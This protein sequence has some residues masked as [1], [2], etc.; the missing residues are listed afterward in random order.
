MSI[1][2]VPLIP[3]EELFGDPMKLSPRVSPDGT[4]FAYLAP[5]EGVLN[6][7]LRTMGKDD[8][9]PITRER[10]RGIPFF[11]FTYDNRHILYINDKDG[12]ENYRIHAVDLETNEIRDL[13]PVEGVQARIYGFDHRFPNEI[14]IGLNDRDARVHDVH[15]LNIATGELTLEVENQDGVSEWL[16]DSQFQVRGAWVPTPDG[17]NDLRVRDSAGDE[18]RVLKSW[19][20]FELSGAFGWTDD[21]SGI[22]LMD[23]QDTDKAELRVIDAATGE[24]KTL[25]GDPKV[26][27]ADIVMRRIDRKVQAA[28]F[29]SGRINWMVL[30]PDVERDFAYLQ[31]AKDGQFIIVSRDLA[32]NLWIVYYDLD[33]TPPSYYLYDRRK[34][35]LEFLFTSRPDLEKYPLAEMRSIE[36]KSRDGLTLHCYLS[37]PP[38]AEARNLPMVLNVHG[39]PWAQDVWG[40]AIEPQWLA[41]RGYACLQV[42]YRGSTGYGKSFIN[43]GN[44][45]W[46]GKMHDDLID[47]VNWAIFEGI[48]DPKRIAIYGGSYGGYAALVGAAF[49]PK[50]FCCAVDIVGISNMRTFLNSL[51]PYW[52]IMRN[53]LN[54]RVGRLDETD[55]LDSRSP[56]FKADQIECPLMIAQGANDPRVKQAESEQI[57]ASL[58]ERGKPVEYILFQDEGHGFARP[59]NRLTFYAAAEKF[60][61][62]HLGG[63]CL[64]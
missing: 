10:K 22:Y 56:L 49:T 27:L 4:R 52:E 11:F 63:R 44:R 60:L 19:G 14:L 48:A 7:W 64:E 51:P 23:S 47:A 59:E 8:D 18:W 31:T 13:T 61:A 42:N 3:R 36:I 6:V 15:R 12:D 33:D 37:L 46:G 40:F 43:A 55:F 53:M 38:G 16:V 2:D 57:V 29:R 1:S 39:G 62:E 50:V 24:V 9:R 58:R 28:G 41:N 45:E 32:D 25:A 35:S 30:D 20:P 5:D 34:Q 54:L 21:G 17:G 26:D